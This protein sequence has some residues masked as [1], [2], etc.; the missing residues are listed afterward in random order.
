MET[1]ALDFGNFSIPIWGFSTTKYKHEKVEK[2]KKELKFF[3]WTLPVAITSK[4]VKE[5]EILQKAIRKRGKKI[6][7]GNCKKRL[8]KNSSGR[9]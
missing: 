6:S 2:N 9:S 7:A 4:T 8:A 1:N 3:K 5:V